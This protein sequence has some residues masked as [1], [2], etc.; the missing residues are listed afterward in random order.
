MV[1]VCSTVLERKQ[2]CDNSRPFFVKLDRGEK[3]E[4]PESGL[5]II[6][7]AG[8]EKT[9]L[10]SSLSVWREYDLVSKGAPLPRFLS[11]S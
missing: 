3:V 8:Y 4:G 10:G 5:L 11:S 1:G 9:Y 7:F 2:S 6:R